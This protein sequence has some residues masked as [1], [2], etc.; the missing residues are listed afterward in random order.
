M[1]A[2][3]FAEEENRSKETGNNMANKRA[4]QKPIIQ[5]K[6]I[7]FFCG[8]GGLDL[9]FIGGF[10][11][12]GKRYN[13]LPFVI[14]G[15]YDFDKDCVTTYS[16]NIGAHVTQ[17]DLSDYTPEK[18]P[19][20]DVLLGGFPCQDF[21]TCGPRRG[22]SSDRGKLYLALIRYMKVHRPKIAVGENVPGLENLHDGEV[23]ETIQDDL[24]QCGYRVKVWK[25]SGPDYGIPQR[26]TRLFI[27]CVR[28]DLKGFPSKPTARFCERP[29]RHTIR[30]A[31]E[32]LESVV[33]E[34]IPNQSQYFKASRAKKGNG[35]GDEVS[36]PNKP[37]YT[38]R[39]KPQSRIQFHYRLNRRLTIRECARLQTFPDDFV[40]PHSATTNILQIGNAVPPIMGHWVANS[41]AK[42]LGEID[43]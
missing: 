41:I 31:I 10:T 17:K 34:S 1:I 29:Y 28:D 27:V 40:F 8:C 36:D 5:H 18:L 4:Q 13:D 32:D 7:S 22:L 2:F 21:A 9:G 37:S 33:D 20:A 12:K 25:L 3:V 43:E 14:E 16:K 19:A 26:R 11:Y 23:L 6:A 35:Q 24:A 42:F 39:A 38:I 30:W 15:A